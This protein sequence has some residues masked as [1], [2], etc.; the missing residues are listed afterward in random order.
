VDRPAISELVR[1]PLGNTF[2]ITF[3]PG[4]E[5]PSHRNPSRLLLT[6]RAGGGTITVDGS[7]PAVLALGACVQL[8]PDVPHAL[9]ADAGGMVVDVLLAAACCPSC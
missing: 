4:Q 3:A 1:G 6:V 5:L 7:G 2:T 8:D 9:T